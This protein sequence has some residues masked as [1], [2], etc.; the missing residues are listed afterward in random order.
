MRVSID[1]SINLIELPDDIDNI[2]G[3][4]SDSF[5]CRLHSSKKIPVWGSQD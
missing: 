4:T 1:L 3:N 2:F 5:S